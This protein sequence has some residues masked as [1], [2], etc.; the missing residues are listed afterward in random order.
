LH[1]RKEEIKIVRER[2]RRRKKGIKREGMRRM[3]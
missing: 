2:D 1:W 3:D